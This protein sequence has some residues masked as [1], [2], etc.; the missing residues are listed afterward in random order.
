MAARFIFRF[1]FIPA[2]AFFLPLSAYA[3]DPDALKRSIEE[4][5]RALQEVNEQI[6]E[7]HQGLVSIGEKGKTLTREISAYEYRIRQLTL[8]IRASQIKIEKYGIEI[9]GFENDI[10]VKEGEVM[11]M[12]E[13][14]VGLL[15]ELQSR[16]RENILLTFLKNK[17]LAEGLFEQES[18]VRL[19]EGLGD[20]VEKLEAIKSE[21]TLALTGVQTKKVAVE[22]EERTLKAR[23]AVS[24]EERQSRTSLLN[25][26]KNQERLYQDQLK[27]LEKQQAAIAEEIEAIE[28]ELRAKIDPNLLPIPR[29]GVLGW[30]AVSTVMSQGYGATRFA[31]RN[32][33]G[34]HHNGVDIAGPIGTEIY[35]AEEGVV[36]A[37][38]N[39]DRFCPR[40]AYG[41]FIVVRHG[42]G[43]TTLYGH[44]SSQSVAAGQTVKRGELIGLMGRSGWAT[45]SHLHFT[46]WSSIT[47][48][49]K[50]TSSCGL[51]PVGGDLDPLQYLERPG[52]AS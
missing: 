4:K 42:N 20:E 48:L 3:L 46:V 21:L 33:R 15:R 16:D 25:Q 18:T 32:Y 8:G 9:E 24:E 7:T 51:M 23:K 17:S 13:G 22:I 14:I 26:T 40:A 37:I 38:G 31:L 52:A 47:N 44:L 12:R 50:P 2:L 30:P 10:S 1:L 49:M 28:R 11:K 5:A 41:K 29:P 19:S 36:M 6:Q 39:Q 45:G 35:A 34:K 43:L 27:E